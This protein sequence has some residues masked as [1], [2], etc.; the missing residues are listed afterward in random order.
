MPTGGSCRSNVSD[1]ARRPGCG[2][3]TVLQKSAIAGPGTG[4]RIC[5]F[6]SSECSL[7]AA[8]GA[9]DG[10]TDGLALATDLPSPSLFIVSP[11]SDPIHQTVSARIG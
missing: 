2:V 9:A 8:I 7:G 11:V 3:G 6:A 1:T 5:C 4:G 10:F